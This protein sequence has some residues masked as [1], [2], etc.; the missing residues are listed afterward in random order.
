VVA[1]EDSKARAGSIFI[2]V[3]EVNLTFRRYPNPKEVID[4]GNDGQSFE[5]KSLEEVVGRGILDDTSYFP[6]TM[7]LLRNPGR[8]RTCL[9]PLRSYRPVVVGR[10]ITSPISTATSTSIE[11]PHTVPTID[12]LDSHILAS[13]RHMI[14]LSTQRRDVSRLRHTPAITSLYEMYDQYRSNAHRILEDFV[15]VTEEHPRGD[16]RAVAIS[17]SDPG[18]VDELSKPGTNSEEG[19]GTVLVVHAML[20]RRNKTNGGIED[21][22]IDKMSVCSGF[23]LNVRPSL[24]GIDNNSEVKAIDQEE[25][26]G[27]EVERGEGAFVMTC[28]HTLEEV[29]LLP[30]PCSA[31]PS[32]PR[33]IQ[34]H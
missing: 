10:V 22:Q 14:T 25:E 9:V 7:I 6:I 5:P 32:L 20:K 33:K 8:C 24:V 30:P 3:S 16:R 4:R 28:A 2:H 13:L 19:D 23:V 31:V 1:G 34:S 11:D 26:G 15:L 27:S 12:P 17:S 18:S 29:R 21:L